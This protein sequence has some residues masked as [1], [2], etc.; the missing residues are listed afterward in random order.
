[1]DPDEYEK[2]SR[3]I[4]SFHT[5]RHHLTHPPE[6]RETLEPR[7]IFFVTFDVKAKN[8]PVSA[9]RLLKN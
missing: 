3:E 2:D 7:I 1:M 8:W 5:G 9:K 4:R 6:Y